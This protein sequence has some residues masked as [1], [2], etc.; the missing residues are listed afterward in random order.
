LAARSLTDAEWV[1]V[2]EATERPARMVGRK[3]GVDDDEV[4]SQ[5]MIG[6]GSL[7]DRGGIF[8]DS[9]KAGDWNT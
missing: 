9:D 8:D 1:T 2:W 4:R 6:I 3:F 5:A 7:R